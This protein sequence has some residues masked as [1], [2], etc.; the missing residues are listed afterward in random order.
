MNCT[1]LANIY[2][3]VIQNLA[4]HVHRTSWHYGND[5]QNEIYGRGEKQKA[6]W[7]CFNYGNYFK[8]HQ[9]FRYINYIVFRLLATILTIFRQKES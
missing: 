3:F 5:L 7:S 2:S 9:D 1:L 8:L 6:V 4:Q